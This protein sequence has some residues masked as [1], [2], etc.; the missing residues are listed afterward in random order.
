MKYR[1]NASKRST[2]IFNSEFLEQIM[3]GQRSEVASVPMVPLSL[4]RTW[5]AALIQPRTETLKSMTPIPE[6]GKLVY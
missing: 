1:Y 3:S 4:A 5:N 6:Y 2:V